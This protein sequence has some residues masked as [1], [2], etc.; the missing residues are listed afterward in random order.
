MVNAFENFDF[1][2]KKSSLNE[3]KCNDE[4]IWTL[5]SFRRREDIQL[6]TY[7]RFEIKKGSLLN[8]TEAAPL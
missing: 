6:E 5:F 7:Q 2:M 1:L 8:D 4:Y 3:M